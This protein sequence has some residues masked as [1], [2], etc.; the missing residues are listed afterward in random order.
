M[1][2]VFRAVPLRVRPR[3]IRSEGMSEAQVLIITLWSGSPSKTNMLIVLPCGLDSEQRPK[4]GSGVPRV[5]E[6]C[7]ESEAWLP[8]VRLELSGKRS[9]LD[10][11]QAPLRN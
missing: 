2:S 3:G 6:P 1:F 7:Q 8:G 4:R 9:P 11:G 10:L 5:Y